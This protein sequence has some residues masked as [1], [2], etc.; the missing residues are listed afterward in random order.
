MLA[1]NSMSSQRRLSRRAHFGHNW[2]K[3]HLL[4][5]RTL[6]MWPGLAATYLR[7]HGASWAGVKQR[8]RRR[9]RIHRLAP[10][11]VSHS[12]ADSLAQPRR[13]SGIWH[14]RMDDLVVGRLLARP[15]L[16]SLGCL[17]SLAP[18]CRD[19]GTPMLA[20]HSRSQRQTAS[21][22]LLK[23][24]RPAFRRVLRVLG[25]QLR[26]LTPV[27]LAVQCTVSLARI[28]RLPC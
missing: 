28:H 17:P 6:V 27:W 10:A 23:A 5:P 25:Q 1:H 3:T 24:H 15:A 18:E 22:L 21:V 11:G 16:L 13:Y 4:T 7:M 12:K 26:S 14:N 8:C 20:E 2:V 9:W 19:P